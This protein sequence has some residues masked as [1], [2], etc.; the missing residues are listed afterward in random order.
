MAR[1]H[2]SPMWLLPADS[3]SPMQTLERMETTT[4][5]T[6]IS[7]AD[8]PITLPD[9]ARRYVA[10]AETRGIP[11]SLIILP[12]KGHEILGDPAVLGRVSQALRE[13]N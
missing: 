2:R 9:Y 6:A 4:E 10:K 8:D 1:L 13:A 11:A 7:G 5:V 12:G 3:L